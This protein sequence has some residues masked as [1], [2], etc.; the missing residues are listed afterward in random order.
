MNLISFFSRNNSDNRIIFSQVVESRS[1]SSVVK[2]FKG[3]SFV[4]IVVGKEKRKVLG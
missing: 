1:F 2:V 4:D 3:D